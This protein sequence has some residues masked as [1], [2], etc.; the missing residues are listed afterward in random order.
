MLQFHTCLALICFRKTLL[1]YRR[2]LWVVIESS[3][4]FFLIIAKVS[5]VFM[6]HNLSYKRIVTY[7]IIILAH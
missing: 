3:K 2:S 4:E 5:A 6:M 1:S 7:V